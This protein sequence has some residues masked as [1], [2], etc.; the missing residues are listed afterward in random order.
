M[1]KILV[2]GIG[3]PLM[4]DEGIGGF[5][6]GELKK[7]RQKF[8]DVEFLDAG[9]GGMTLLHKINS[10]EKLILIDCAK[11]R[12]PPGTIKKF[13]PEQ[14]QSVKKLMHYSLHEAD[15]L[16]ILEI[17]EKLGERPKKVIIFAIE[18][19]TIET[20]QALSKTLSGKIQ[21]YTELILSELR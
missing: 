14:V 7:Y 19:E 17:S 18:P 4:A 11:M 21:E 2:A 5:L 15:I 12:T 20:K 16:K 13:S 1:K 10:R 8:P 3:N 9:S 6:I